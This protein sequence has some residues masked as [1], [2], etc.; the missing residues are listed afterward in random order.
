MGGLAMTEER[1]DRLELLLAT[2]GSD[3]SRRTESWALGL[4]VAGHRRRVVDVACVAGAG[5]VGTGWGASSDRPAVRQAIRELQEGELRTAE[6]VANAVADRIQA[7]TNVTVRT[8]ARQ[9]VIAEELICLVEDIQPDIVIVGHRGRSRLVHLILGSV[10]NALIAHS[11]RATLVV[12]EEAVDPPVPRRP[13]VVFDGTPGAE[14]MVRWLA[15]IGLTEDADVTI[16]GLPDLPSGT[17]E[18][19]RDAAPGIADAVAER[20]QREVEAQ[21]EILAGTARVMLRTDLGHPVDAVRR[22][23]EETDADL[24]VVARHLTPRGR[25]AVADEIVRQAGHAVL[26]VPVA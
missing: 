3:E 18:S 12:R 5:I 10:A 24:V 1:T 25:E 20:V 23:I 19:L 16:L 14:R 9:G 2:D 4:R 13:L 26:V 8:W 17:P 22:A 21:R 7:D 6:R 11:P 15:D